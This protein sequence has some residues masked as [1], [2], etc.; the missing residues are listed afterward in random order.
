MGCL[1]DTE[2]PVD[3]TACWDPW[4]F[5]LFERS[6]LKD[7]LCGDEADFGKH[8]IPKLL[9]KHGFFAYL[10]QGYWEDIAPSGLLRGQPRPL[11][12]AP[13][14]Q[15]LRRDR[16][17]VYPRA[18]PARPPRSSRADRAVADCRWVCIINDARI[19][20]SLVG[21]RSRIDAGTSLRDTLVW[22]TISTNHRTGSSTGA[23]PMGI[24]HG[25]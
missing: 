23:P 9:A 25:T 14:V 19:E 17:G 12:A 13:E 21:V 22:D 16:A 3:P 4:G 18:V 1:G 15:L 24:G 2:E 8:V 10:H 6:V 20:H 11:R 7:A 5:Y